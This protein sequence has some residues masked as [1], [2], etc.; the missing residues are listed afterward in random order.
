[1]DPSEIIEGLTYASLDNLSGLNISTHKK[2]DG[3]ES[4]NFLLV[5]STNE[6]FVLKVYEDFKILPVISAENDLLQILAL[7]S[8]LSLPIPVKLGD[9]F[10]SKEDNFYFRILTYLEGQAWAEFEASPDH[11]QLFATNT[12]LLNLKCKGFTNATISA[13]RISWDLK[14]A[15]DCWDMAK[16]ITNPSQK[17]LVDYFLDRFQYFVLPSLN[18]LPA[19]IIHN[20]LNDWNVFYNQKNNTLSFIDFGDVSFSPKVCEIGIALCYLLMG[21][22][23]P[24][25]IASIYL[26]AYHKVFPLQK[27]ELD[28]L[29]DLIATR[30]C[31]SVCHSAKAKSEALDTAYILLS[32]KPAWAL[33][34]RWITINPHKAKTVF[35]EACGIDPLVYDAKKVQNNRSTYFSG[36]LALSYKNPIHFN[37]SAFQYLYDQ[38]GNCFLDAYNNIPLVGHC[39]PEI[40]RR[41]SEQVRTLNTNTRYH[42]TQLGTYAEKLLSYFPSCLNKVFFVNSGS[43]AADLARRLVEN[44]TH[45]QNHIVLEHGYHGN[46]TASLELSH[47]KFA[48]KGGS[49]KSPNILSLPLPKSFKGKFSTTEEYVE[50][51]KEKLT[52]LLNKDVAFSSLIAEPISGCGGQV[53]IMPGYLKEL[54]RFLAHQETLLVI[55]EVQ[56]G[57]GR[58][59]DIFWG[60][61]MHGIIP[62]VVI[63]GKAM[64]N[65]HPLAAVVCRKDIADAFDNGMEFFSSF[66]GNPVSCIVGHTVLEILENE[67]LPHNAT[68]VGSY[69]LSELNQLKGKYPVIGDV[70]GKGL[71]IGIE[72]VDPKTIEPDSALAEKIKNRLREKLIL[73]STDGP[74]NNVL[75]VKP[76]LCFEKS[77]VDT[78]IASLDQILSA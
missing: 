48:G 62:D 41:I 30:L 36:S 65:G 22:E 20:D 11:I 15:L 74:Y 9:A 4:Q 1:M 64:G 5:T 73:S 12:A 32:E 53:P 68:V 57:F 34:K 76:P 39:H 54:Q 21:Q 55:D 29:Y 35:Y 17:K 38:N 23:D 33:L 51:A 69:W 59:G 37:S 61:E 60:Y 78:F 42:Y 67:H 45:R 43:A 6:K 46:S 28:L 77:N 58:L 26:A 70:R 52:A 14:H 44:F 7:D 47:Y 49:G 31:V 18:K 71:F 72:F 16:N 25:K 2:L 56:T 75:K 40:S 24:L 19:Q 8:D 3:Y 50:D 13:R 27:K 63:L 66:G 10:I